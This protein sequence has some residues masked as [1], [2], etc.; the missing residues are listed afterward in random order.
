MSALYHAWRN[1][2]AA[3]CLFGAAL[4]A[5]TLTTCDLKGTEA[6]GGEILAR[7]HCSTCHV[8]PEPKLLPRS[9]WLKK[10]LPNMAARMGFPMGYPYKNLRAEDM[11]LVINAH[12]I[13]DKPVIPEADMLKIVAWYEANAP[14]QP[15]PQQRAVD[16]Q[17][18]LT[19]FRVHPLFEKAPG[20]QNIL[21][22]AIPSVPGQLLC[23]FE[24]RGVWTGL[25][26]SREPRQ[27]AA[28]PAVDA[29]W[30]GDALYLLDIRQTQAYN[31]PLGGLWKMPW[32]GGKSQGKPE[33]LIDSLARPVS[34]AV[35]DLNAD[36][37]PDFAI[38]EFGD[39]LGRLSLHLSTP[40]GYRRSALKNVPGACKVYF[41][42]M[43]ADGRP[44]LVVLMSQGR[45]EICIFYNTGEG[46]FREQSIAA[47]PPS[48]G[49]NA[50]LI[51][52]LN[53]DGRPDLLTTHGDNAD[54]SSSLKSYHG[55]RYFENEG[56]GQ[57]SERWFYP[58]HGASGVAAADFD[59]DGDLDLVA[60]AHFPDFK[61]KAPE[62]LLYFEN[63]GAGQL[64][65]HSLPN[66]LN[67]RL[68]TLETA[69]IDQDGDIDLFIGNYLDQ[70][71]PSGADRYAQWKAEGRDGWWLENTTRSL[72]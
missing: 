53:R 69:D 14:E 4:I 33:F 8:F 15:L 47:F 18:D 13:P 38:A 49:S 16:P 70:L 39:Y 61:Q 10:V 30:Y 46:Q 72:K 6:A 43:D 23:G 35:S 2:A 54:I 25:P 28:L 57:F 59:L 12:I 68:L 32:R 9:V 36:G 62:N 50:L 41:Q 66:P 60:I 3:V 44:D 71:T 17:P 19:R 55:L 26:G 65:P 20:T 24:D 45:E 52:D 31:L 48:Y 56:N 7:A 64:V 22:K 67:G 51:A 40:Q 27:L 58:M 29:C 37:K 42:D 11:E 34:L 63:K 5:G 1:I 21:L